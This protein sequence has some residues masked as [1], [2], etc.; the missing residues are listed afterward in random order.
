MSNH[1]TISQLKEIINVI[2][3]HWIVG[4]GLIAERDV[5]NLFTK[6]PNVEGDPTHKII[7]FKL[8]RKQ[9]EESPDNG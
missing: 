2:P 1:M 5:V 8:R 4:V 6:N 3:D 9:K 7:G